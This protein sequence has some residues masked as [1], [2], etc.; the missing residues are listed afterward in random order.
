MRNKIAEMKQ[1]VSENKKVYIASVGGVV[2]GGVGVFIGSG[3]GIQFVD[4]LKLVHI[5]WKS[6]NVAVTVLERRG[7]REAIP[8]IWRKT[9]E[10]FASIRRAAEVS[11][12]TA[13]DIAADV[14]GLG[15]NFVR[16]PDSILAK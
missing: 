8:V 10:P 15:E 13:R 6:P 12:E 9:G 3:G 7:C 11:G 5:Q 2:V 14:H 16:A 1:H 4:S